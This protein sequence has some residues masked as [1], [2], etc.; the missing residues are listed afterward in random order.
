MQDLNIPALERYIASQQPSA[1]SAPE[2]FVTD[3]YRRDQSGQHFP[4]SI[5]ELI[6]L[7]EPD[8]RLNA[9]NELKVRLPY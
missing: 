1:G 6:T 7:L 8:K 9:A 3:D 4:K 2:P 5:G